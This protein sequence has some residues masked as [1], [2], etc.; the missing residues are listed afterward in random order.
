MTTYLEGLDLS[1]AQTRTPK[2]AGLSFVVVKASEGNFKDSRW[3]QHS[4]AVR[5][6]GLPLLAYHF[7]R[8]E[9]SVSEQLDIFESVSK[10]ADAWVL[11]YEPSPTHHSLMTQAQAREFIAAFQ[12]HDEIGLYGAEHFPWPTYPSDSFGADWRWVA[13]QSQEPKVPFDIWQW[14]GGRMDRDRA[15][16]DALAK[17][18][19]KDTQ[20]PASPEEPMLNL[21]PLT[22]HRVLDLPAGTVLT[23]TPDGDRYT[24]LSKAATLG[25]L[26]ATGTH[27]CVAD[28][29]A[30]VYVPRTGLTPRTQDI[31]AGA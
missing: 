13:N 10:S 7:G 27:Y 9:W 23:K 22:A 31:S 8:A 6:A 18:L 25:L 26:G 12:Q 16:P 28:G 15:T 17:V 20:P 14:A 3:D 1:Y 4:K 11:D 5:A 21:V 29:D 19:R 24:Q 2:L 30:G